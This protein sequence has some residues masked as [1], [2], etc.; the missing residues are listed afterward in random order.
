[1][2]KL[3]THYLQQFI[4]DWNLKKHFKGLMPNSLPESNMAATMA[5]WVN[6]H[7]I[8]SKVDSLMK[9]VLVANTHLHVSNT[10]NCIQV[11]VIPGMFIPINGP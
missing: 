11:Q 2:K 7:D 9:I 4:I 6:D 3:H 10:T 1:M 5:T 8:C